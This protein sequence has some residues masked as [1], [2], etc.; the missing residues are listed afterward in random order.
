MK[1]PGPVL[2]SQTRDAISERAADFLERRRFGG[3]SDADQ[4]GLDAWLAESFLH[5]AAYLRLEGAVAYAEELVALRPS[6]KSGQTAPDGDGKFLHRRFVLPLLIAASASLFAALGIP[7]VNSL[8]Q[9]PD[10]SFST[11]VGG[12]SLVKFADGTEIELNTDTAMRFRMTTA[13]RTVWLDKG[14]AWFRVAHNA[15]NPFTV[16]IGRHRVTDLGTEFLV[17]RGS[18]GME[19]ALLN[20]RAMLNTEG[21]LTTMLTPGDDAV[22]T[23]ISVSVTRKTPQELADALAWRHGVLVFRKTKLADAVREFNRYNQTKLVIADP[24]IADLTFS[25]EIKDDN[26][27]GFLLVAESMLKL[28]ADLQGNDILLSRDLPEK[29]KKAAREKRNP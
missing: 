24:S 6:P 20:G 23:P 10:R 1:A 14:E 26:F 3:W 19:V 11:D 2:S 12:R 16:V 17:R 5:R 8:L 29:T 7:F 21:A 13:E 25:A 22:A 15:A 28:R 9:P 18:N 27:N 4:A